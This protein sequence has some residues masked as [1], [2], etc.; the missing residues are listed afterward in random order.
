MPDYSPKYVDLYDETIRAIVERALNS[1]KRWIVRLDFS[2]A[3]R[4]QSPSSE[5][6][7]P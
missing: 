2:I 1:E 4:M 6:A 5:R 3:K 7:D